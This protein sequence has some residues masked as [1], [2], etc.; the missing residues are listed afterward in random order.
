MRKSLNLTQGELK[1]GTVGEWQGRG[2]GAAWH[3]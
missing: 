1:H 2:K 3:M